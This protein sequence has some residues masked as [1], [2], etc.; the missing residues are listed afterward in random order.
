MHETIHG[1]DVESVAAHRVHR[2]E[3]RSEL[4]IADDEIV[5]ADGVYGLDLRIT[6]IDSD[7]LKAVPEGEENV[8]KRYEDAINGMHGDDP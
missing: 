7:A 8:V 3:V 2:D 1:I 6:D 5:I 4:G